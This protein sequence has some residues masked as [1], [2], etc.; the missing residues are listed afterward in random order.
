MEKGDYIYDPNTGVSFILKDIKERYHSK[1]LCESFCAIVDGVIVFDY[2]SGLLIPPFNVNN[3]EIIEELDRALFK[4]GY[5]FDTE[6]MEMSGK[7]W[8]PTDEHYCIPY[9]SQID[10]P[11]LMDYEN[12]LC[13]K[14]EKEAAKLEEVALDAI[15][16]YLTKKK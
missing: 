1:V 11:I 14:T 8:M 15:R 7:R 9:L 2:K 5:Y 10:F 3:P 16:K 6:K 4:E 13:C 12:G